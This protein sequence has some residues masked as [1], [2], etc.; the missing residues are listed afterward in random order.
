MYRSFF[1]VCLLLPLFWVV[2]GCNDDA[3]IESSV[4]IGLIFPV[5][6]SE[7]K[8]LHHAAILASQHLAEAGFPIRTVVEDSKFD[9][10]LS[11][12]AARKFVEN[13]NVKIIIGAAS[14]DS[15]MEVAQWVSIPEQIP[16]ISYASTSPE[17]TDLNDKN[18]DGKGFVF[19]TVPSDKIQGIILA[20]LAEQKYN[21]V[22][23]VYRQGS[24]GENLSSIFAE[25]FQQRVG[26]PVSLHQHSPYKRDDFEENINSQIE[27]DFG[28]FSSNL[29]DDTDAIVAISYRDDSDIYIT[30]ALK[31]QKFQGIDFLFVDGN[32]GVTIF[33]SDKNKDGVNEDAL[34]GMCGT[35]PSPPN[36]KL[37]SEEDSRLIFENSYDTV[38]PKEE[39]Q[40]QS[41]TET[42]TFLHH[43]YDAVIVAGLAAY[44]AIKK[45]NNEEISPEDIRDQIKIVAN[46]QGEKVGS[47]VKNIK[48]ALELLDKGKDVNYEGASGNVDFDENGDVVAPIG[49]WCYNNGKIE[50]IEICEVIDFETVPKQVVCKKASTRPSQQ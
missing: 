34:N 14:S 16:Q 10:F 38:F 32:K 29:P 28:V 39:G 3:G 42:N 46:P 47:G 35:V 48:K 19:R 30:R 33:K 13:H 25:E 36:Y 5:S 43:S 40:T 6:S 15:T 21:N 1:Y 4:T 17:I 20:Y 27:I 18:E 22:S 49:I 45:S 24:Y 44:S 11:V 8:S 41:V 23:V 37:S 12:E 7:G 2:S 31:Q 26:T 9:P 50:T